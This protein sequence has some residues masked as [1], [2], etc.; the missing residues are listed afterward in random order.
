MILAKVHE[1]QVH[2]VHYDIDMKVMYSKA[3]YD[4]LSGKIDYH[5]FLEITDTMQKEYLFRINKLLILK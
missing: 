3:I 1:L 5:E 2:A 4:V